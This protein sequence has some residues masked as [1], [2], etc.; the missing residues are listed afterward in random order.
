MHRLWIVGLIATCMPLQAEDAFSMLR[1]VPSQVNAVAVINTKAILE[2][3]R[4]QKEG[5]AKLT[6]TEYLAGAVPL[7]PKVER[8]VF[9][10]EVVPDSPGEGDVLAVLAT[11]EPFDAAK[12]AAIVGGKEIT[13]ANEPAIVN[14]AG[15][16]F[17][18]LGDKLIGAMRCDSKQ[19]VARWMKSNKSAKDSQL[20][21]I[22]NSAVANSAN[23]HIT[24]CLDADELFDERGV[25]IAVAIA[26]SI[27]TNTDQVKA[28]SAFFK[29]LKGVTFTANITT[30][31]IAAK[32][33]F[34]SSHA[35]LKL[36]PEFAK[37]FVVETLGNH[38]AMLQDLG[39]AKASK[40]QSDTSVIL[41][42]MV[43]DAELGRIM[44]LILPPA[45]LPQ[46]EGIVV[47]P[48]EPNAQATLKYF[49]AV[50]AILDDLQTQMKKAKDYTKTALWHET[51]AQK[52]EMLATIG[53]DKSVIEY[54]QGSSHRLGVIAESLRGVPA[55]LDDLQGQAYALGYVP[56]G[57]ARRMWRY[58]GPQ[59]STNIGEIANKQ[60]QVVKDDE[61]NRNTVWGQIDGK[62][63]E[64]RSLIAEKYKVVPPEKK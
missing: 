15:S 32:V 39:S 19:D 59:V 48:S 30:N 50:N 44:S 2:S 46:G 26:K 52:I 18:R 36:D 61:K 42:F 23:H 54:G 29:K 12:V 1:F 38:G 8:M 13:I 43:S 37:A 24:L 14:S 58:G 53:V 20:S 28:V 55:K 22:L 62:R 51:A 40:T 31:G 7:H 34:E 16:Y 56:R 35:G 25:D 45:A 6:Y 21:R 4:A 41:D 60:A 17:I 9:A 64:M 3:Q 11:K 63:S 5:W 33:R 27:Q 57:G 47:S 49:N 10:K